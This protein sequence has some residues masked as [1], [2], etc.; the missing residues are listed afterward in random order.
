MIFGLKKVISHAQRRSLRRLWPWG[1]SV[2][3]VG[4]ILTTH[5]P[6]IQAQSEDQVEN[7]ENE[8]IQQFS[9]PEPAPQAPVVQPR[10]QAPAPQRQSPPAPRQTT[11]PAP[12]SES[13]PEPRPE[14]RPAASEPPV[15][16]DE[17]EAEESAQASST[18]SASDSE[19]NDQTNQEPDADVVS[20]ISQY[21]LQ[22]NRSPVVSNALQME[23]VLSQARLGFTRP[24]NWQVESAKVQINFRHSPALFA[25]RSNLTV[26][27]NNVHLGS[28]PLNRASDEIGKVLF[29]VPAETIQDYNTIVMQV[30]QHTSP[31][32]TDP[33]DPTL[34]TEILPD[35]QV[36]INYRPQPIALDLSNYPYPFLNGLGLD[37]DKLTYLQPNRPDDVWMTAAARYQ[38]SA[39]RLSNFRSIQ[40]RLVESPDALDEGE[41]LVVIGTPT[42][43]P[44]MSELSL[45]FDIQ[46]NRVLDGGGNALPNDVG[47]IM[48][49]TTT[50]SNNPVLVVTGNGAPGV[51]KG[52]QALA[53]RSD[54]QLLTGQAAL[55]TEVAEVESPEPRDWPGYLPQGVKRFR[56]SDLQTAD[57]QPFQDVTVNGLPVPP[58]VSIP[59]RSLPD[60]QFLRGSTFTLRYSYGPNIDP[61]RSSVSVGIDGQALGGE[62]LRKVNGGTD[63][64]TV[65]IPPAVV[66]PS[67][68][69]QVQFFTYPKIPLSCGNIPDQPMWGTVHG[70]S[71]FNLN[72]TSVVNLPDLKL[73]QTGFPLTAPQDLSQMTFVLPE[74]PNTTEML[75]L[76]QASSRFGRLSRADSVKLGAYSAVSLPE[77]LRRNSNLVGIGIRDRFPL[78]ELFEE[79][80]GFSLGAQFLRRQDRSQIQALPDEAGVIEATVSPW[81]GERILV[82]LTGQ[83]EEG[84]EDIQQVFY[85]DSL[86][87]RLEGD[88]LLVQRTTDSPAI[89]VADNFQ[90]TTF[91]Q[92]AVTTVD[93][94]GILN[95]VVALI[96]ANWFLIPGGFVLIVLML[97]GVSQLYLNR[98]SHSEG[99]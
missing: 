66:T 2:I 14:P 26:R 64:I 77:D 7:Q 62:R 48:L 96:Q 50:D 22:F 85:Q 39:A 80:T 91:S 51:L 44:L 6:S 33:T 31:N 20:P 74:R 59:F 4:L 82:G 92:N 35:S 90:V 93:R 9:L 11:Q 71:S 63:S 52:V 70:D 53:Q 10:R 89:S 16:D 88:T 34:W 17:S 15:A 67:S 24:A 47:I 95:R 19:E 84:I 8:L 36:L 28:V 42:T 55:V 12:R 83:S 81:N 38:A 72:R 69:L 49:T 57:L 18:G 41:R 58:A 1:L 99:A 97:Y 56:L 68:N 76:L 5:L 40:T 37:A 46:N 79:T 94:R 43:Q 45:P 60:D 25:E 29:D 21:V 73:L 13:R 61:S 32:C 98:V 27:L 23:G 75:M 78:P 54:R 3:C 65:N 86:F 30:Q 87:S